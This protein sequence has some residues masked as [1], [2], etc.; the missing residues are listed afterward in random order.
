MNKLGIF[1]NFWERNWAADHTKYIRKA[2]AIGFDVLEFQAQPL[3][4]MPTEKLKELKALA[5][6]CGIELTYSLGLDPAYD[7]SSADPAIRAGG[8]DYLQRIVEKIGI[9]EGKLLSGVSYAGWGAPTYIVDD[10][11]A[12]VE[13]SKASMREII[14]TAEAYGV[15]YCVEAVN[16]F[17]GCIINTAQE[18]LD[19]VKDIDSPNLGVLLDT[20]HMNIE[21]RSIGEAIHLVGDRLTSFHI[22]ENNRSVP[23]RGHLDWNEI[24]GALHDIGYEGRIV[25][26][27][28]V[29]MGGEAGRDIK[30]WRNLIDDPT[31]A[32]L[33]AEAA[34]LLEFTRKMLKSV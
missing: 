2:A 4:D 12:L 18:A 8:I 27:P 33:D 6:D 20:Y 7:V 34:Y 9:M 25:A 29:L 19:Y 1:M 31:E 11:T 15:T 24:F 21:E 14:R 22:G 30:T 32:G 23:G 16:R 26:E 3:L 17:E 13:R 5:D 28:F 10:K